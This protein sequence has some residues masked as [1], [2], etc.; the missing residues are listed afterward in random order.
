MA[1]SFFISGFSAAE[2]NAEQLFTLYRDSANTA[3]LEKLIALYGD[4]LYHYL[5]RQS[6]R[7]LA[8]D[9][10]Q[11]CWLKLLEQP[12]SFRGNSSFKTWLFSVGRNC[13]IDEMRRHK[14]WQTELDMALLSAEVAGDDGSCPVAQ[15]SQS[16]CQ[17]KWAEQLALLPFLQREALMLQLEGFSLEQISTITGQGE[18]TIKSRLRYARQALQPLNGDSHEQA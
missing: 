6:S 8:E 3:Y 17:L 18:E 11:Q 10:S 5:A 15:L 13:L 1:L 12:Y 2:H 9:V 4:A 7:S 16:Q 14:Y